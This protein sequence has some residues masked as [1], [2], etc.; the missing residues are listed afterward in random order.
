MTCV[1]NAL[2]DTSFQYISDLVLK[3]SAIVLEPVKAYLVESRLSPLARQHG[4]ESIAELVT[5]LRAKPA[6]DLHQLVTEAMTTNETSF[7]RDI[8]P[9][10]TLKTT[11]LPELIAA[12]GAQRALNIWCGACS[13]GQEPYTIGIVLR[14]HF[15]TLATWNVRL[16]ASDLSTQILARAQQGLY[17]QAEVNRGMPAPLLVKHFHKVGLQWQVKDHVRNLMQFV[18]LNL[19]ERWPPLSRMDIIFLRNVLIYFSSDTKR[20]ILDK[21]ARQLAPDGYLFLGG[22]ETTLNLSEAFDRVNVGKTV[23]YRLRGK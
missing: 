6:G 18:E 1:A 7:F 12:R 10:D 15:P 23:C 9:F 16:V 17:T 20:A 2:D 22:A 13:S 14:E 4:F 21:I 5:A 8:H 19:I 11:I 3:R